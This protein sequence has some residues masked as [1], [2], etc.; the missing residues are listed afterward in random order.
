MNKMSLV[1]ICVGVGLVSL[2]VAV[3]LSVTIPEPNSTVDGII[4]KC[5]TA[6]TVSFFG[7]VGLI[8]GKAGDDK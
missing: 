1:K 6:F 8:T 2:A 5:M 4:D 3:G 7:V